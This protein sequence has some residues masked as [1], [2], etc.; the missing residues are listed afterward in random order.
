M[1]AR[2]EELMQPLAEGQRLTT[3]DGVS[4]SRHVVQES[5]TEAP[6]KRD[7]LTAILESKTDEEL[8]HQA[9]QVERAAARRRKKTS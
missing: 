9:K 5:K 7:K 2:A 3:P 8:E 4:V 6:G 1:K